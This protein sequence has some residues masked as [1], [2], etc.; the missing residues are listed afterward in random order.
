MGCYVGVPI[1]LPHVQYGETLRRFRVSPNGNGSLDLDMAWIRAKISD[2]FK[3][4]H[5]ADV[6]LTYIDEDYDMVQLV[7]DADLWDA[8]N[9]Q[10]LNPLRINVVPIKEIVQSGGF[11]IVPP[12]AASY[13]NCFRCDGCG[14]FPIEGSR[15]K[16]KLK[17]NYDLCSFCF[18][19]LGKEGDYTIIMDNPIMD[20][21]PL[22]ANKVESKQRG[23]ADYPSPPSQWFS[24]F[25]FDQFV[26]PL[27]FQN[28]VLKSTYQ[29]KLGSCFI[30]DVNIGDGM[31]MAPLTQFTK[32]WHMMNNGGVVWPC[33]THLKW[34][35][36]A[37]LTD[38]NSLDIELP[39]E[40]CLVG[41][42]LNVAIDCT[43]PEKPGRFH[44]VWR[45][46]LPSG[47]TFGVFIW[48][49][50]QVDSPQKD[51]R[52]E[53][54]QSLSFNMPPYSE[55]SAAESYPGVVPVVISEPSPV[56]DAPT[57]SELARRGDVLEKSLKELDSAANDYDMF[58]HRAGDMNR[59][60]RHSFCHRAQ[61]MNRIGRHSFCQRAGNYY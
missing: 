12:S 21:S 33:G 30:E 19:D 60:G 39:V 8:I 50:I 52:S 48:V 34:I 28:C 36:G 1:N 11:N 61:D 18:L 44:S 3:F 22:R 5:D 17:E 56:T 58:Y 47:R 24:K 26:N 27:V 55:A 59:I 25:Q 6:T 45:M 40:G 29:P 35:G 54:C 43:A 53:R 4:T 37:R 23:V 7:D 14:I 16:S 41:T 46:A 32:I 51:S 49:H 38:A 9:N 42:D 57:V 31:L 13:E 2:L 10:R 15:Y 20:Q